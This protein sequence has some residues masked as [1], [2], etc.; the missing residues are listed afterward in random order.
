MVIVDF[1]RNKKLKVNIIVC[2]IFLRDL[3]FS[4]RRDKIDDVN[5]ELFEYI[6][7]LEELR[8]ENVFFLLLDKGWI[9]KGDMLDEFLYFIDYLYFVEEGDEKFVKLIVRLVKEFFEVDEI[10][11]D[12]KKLIKVYKFLVYF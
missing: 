6:S 5:E 3:Y 10:E 4:L 11:E 8:D 12:S 7:F 2:G 1:I 9:V